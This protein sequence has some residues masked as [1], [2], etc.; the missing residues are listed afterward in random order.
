[1][2]PSMVVW[3]AVRVPAALPSFVFPSR[4]TNVREF[5]VDIVNVNETPHGLTL[6]RNDINE[7][8]S[9][10]SV[11]GTF[12]GLDVDNGETFTYALTG[13]SND[14]GSFTLTSVGI[15][16]AGESYNYEVKKFAVVDEAYDLLILLMQRGQNIQLLLPFDHG[17]LQS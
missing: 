12:S 1:M 5:D 13:S 16:R 6:S 11:I 14:N 7:N 9:I 3:L 4:L 17:V 8:N 2:I 15:L 10:G